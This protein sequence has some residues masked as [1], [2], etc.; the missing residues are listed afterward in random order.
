VT[1]HFLTNT[2]L[3]YAS[4]WQRHPLFVAVVSRLL[5]RLEALAVLHAG[6]TPDWDGKALKQAAR[7]VELGR[8]ETT[9][10][11]LSRYSHRQRQP[12]PLDGFVGRA[13]YQGDLAPFLPLLRVGEYV[14]V[15]RGCVYG[16]GRM[17]VES[18]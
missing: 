17:R 2:R 6:L 8:D 1:L 16:L 15:G 5:D 3:Q 14:H 10:V 12:Q 4:R 7:E 9:W 11:P 13:T 18:G